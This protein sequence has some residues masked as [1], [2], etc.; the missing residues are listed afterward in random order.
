MSHP[1]LIGITCSIDGRDAR[2]RRAYLDAVRHAGGLPLLIAPAT[3][4]TDAASSN[5][6]P[7]PNDEDHAYADALVER[8]DAIVL[9]GGDDPFME[10]F[11]QPTDP[12]VKPIDPARQRF[13]LALIQSVLTDHQV[14]TRPIL[15]ICLGMQL[16]ALYAEGALE[17]WMP[18]AFPTHES[19][20]DDRAHPIIPESN[21]VSWCPAGTVTSHHR[22]AITNPGQLRVVAR[23]DDGVIEAIDHLH[24]PHCRGVQWH[25]ER[26]ADA[27]L[28]HQLFADLVASARAMRADRL[29]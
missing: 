28:G 11:G 22:Q 13:E 26:T 12:R 15:G 24:H 9:T 19:H 21:R 8:L 10:P 23:A 16:L 5:H 20:W 4:S 6:S 27:G 3:R 14:D 25:P 7:V 2:A 1:P 18:D 17:Q 29:S